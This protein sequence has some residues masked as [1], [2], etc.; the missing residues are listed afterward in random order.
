MYKI[1]FPMAMTLFLGAGAY[2]GKCWKSA[3][4]TM[5]KTFPRAFVAKV[6]K[7]TSEG[8]LLFILLGILADPAINTFEGN[9]ACRIFGKFLSQAARNLLRGPVI[10]QS[11]PHRGGKKSRPL[12]RVLIF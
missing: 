5:N 9:V 8:L 10:P 7:K 6:S 2:A 4:F 11:L 1:A 12:S 3:F